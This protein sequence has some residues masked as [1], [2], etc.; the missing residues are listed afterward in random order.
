MSPLLLDALFSFLHFTALL[1]MAGA[2]SAEAFILRLPASGPQI[3]LLQRV[4]AFY[5]GSSVVLIAAGVCRVLYG[6]K[7]WSYYVEEPFFWA[8]MGMF[9]LVG[10]L[11]IPPTIRFIGWAR[12]LK[13]DA[14]FLPPEAQTKGVRRYVMIELHGLALI[15]VFAVLMARGYGQIWFGG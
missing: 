13:T 12:A 2:L 5:G 6:A 1:V 7:H 3:R 15:V 9:V 4:D 10:L 11:S 14:A 8:K